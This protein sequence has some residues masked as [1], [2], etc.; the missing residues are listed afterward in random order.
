MACFSGPL[1]PESCGRLVGSARVP[2]GK[3]L[4]VTESSRGQPLHS[5]LAG[6]PEMQY[7][8]EF[9]VERLPDRARSMVVALDSG[10]LEQLK[11][12]AHQLKGAAGSYGFFP[13]TDLCRDL[14][15]RVVA[16]MS[17]DEIRTAISLVAELCN[18]ATHLPPG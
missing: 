9:F 1:A 15:A 7:L 16:E 12:L 6:D 11:V 8:L 5:D 17:A 4:E 2:K 18:R 13:I 3:S 10:D 14:E